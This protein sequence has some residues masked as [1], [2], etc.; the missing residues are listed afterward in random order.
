[1]AYETIASHA[2]M[3]LDAVRNDAYARALRQVVRP[4]SV[5]LD[6]GAGTGVF[7][8]MA[9]RMGA[10]RVYL[11][12]PTDVIT[13]AQEIADANG[14]HDVVTCLHGR[15]EDVV[16]PEPADGL[17]PG[18]MGGTASPT[19]F[20]G[21]C[22]SFLSDFMSGTTCSIRFSGGCGVPGAGRSAGEPCGVVVC[23]MAGAAAPRVNIASNITRRFITKT[24]IVLTR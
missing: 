11:V 20:V 4:D 21:G 12:E 13:V 9:A 5:V 3:A 16:V 2:R 10:R 18:F 1:M 23:A 14:L 24:S 17:S 22:C 15:L 6:L 7:G 19:R 8:L